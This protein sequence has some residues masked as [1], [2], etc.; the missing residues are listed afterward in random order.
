MKG[1][2]LK[3][4]LVYVSLCLIWGSTWLAIRYGLE[5]LTP[6][7]SVG[8]RFAL[9]S[10]IIL[11]LMKMKNIFIQKDKVSIRLYLL[12]GFFSFLIP[13]GLV[14]WGMQHVPSGMAS[15]LFAVFPFVVLIFSYLR[16]PSETIGFYKIFGTLLGFAGIVVIFSDSF[17]G[18]FTDY[19]FGMIAI[20]LSGVMQ[21]WIAVSIKKFGH[22]LHP[23]SMNFIPMVIA[24][25]C[26]IFISVFFEDISTV[27]IDQTAVISLLYL[28]VFGSVVT[29]TFYYW[30]L[31]RLNIVI[32]SLIAF[33]TPIVALILG[34]L[35]YQEELSTRHFIGSALVLTGV[36]WAN[37]GNLLKLR[38]GTIIRQ[39]KPED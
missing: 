17:T 39:H 3:V 5:S 8:V 36:F 34:F 4:A 2:G 29:F 24:A 20:V 33:I 26:L 13:F 37:L 15:V 10:V 22:H 14:Y 19:I 35:F 38:K 28:A 11:I 30:L 16:L 1:L 31:K 9:A 21:A 27:R 18:N 23:L 7:F 12:M 6:I 32:L 25:V